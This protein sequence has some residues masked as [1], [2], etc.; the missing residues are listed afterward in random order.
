MY[1]YTAGIITDIFILLM[2]LIGVYF[3]LTALFSL[4]PGGT[5]SPDCKMRSFIAVIPAHNEEKV[6]GSLIESIKGADYPGEL[7]RIVVVDDECSDNTSK[8]AEQSGAIVVKRDRSTCKGAALSHGFLYCEENGLRGDCIVVFDADNLVD[9]NFFREIN[10]RFNLGAEVVQGYIDSKN[11]NRTWVSGGHSMWYWI[12]NRT[13]QTGRA[14]LGMG[15]RIGGTGFAMKREVLTKVPWSTQTIAEDEEYTCMLA[16]NGI[17][18]DYAPRAVVYDEKPEKLYDSIKQRTRWARGMGDVQGEFTW[19]LLKRGKINALLLLWCDVLNPIAFLV[20]LFGTIFKVGGIAN[21][22][23]GAVVMWI[24]ILATIFIHFSALLAD[25]KINSKIMINLTGF[26]VY[27]VSW[28]FIGIKGIFA[29]D[30]T[31][32]HTDHKNKIL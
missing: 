17:K 29:K 25:R 9:K 13:V 31:W 23:I 28:I 12:T 8:I 16:E 7:I 6:I 24:Y 30:N 18:V 21:S 26:A 2:F 27:M 19:R 1:S 22:V 11:P 10:E 15:C 32:Y 4:M 5:V 20:I 14:R 3:L